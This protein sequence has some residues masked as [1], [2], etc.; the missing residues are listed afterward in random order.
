MHKLS[1]NSK[2]FIPRGFSETEKYEKM[3]LQRILSQEII[4]GD[5]DLKNNQFITGLGNIKEVR[6]SLDL[7]KSSIK[8]L[9]RLERVEGHLNLFNSKIEDLGNFKYVGGY[10]NLF[11]TP[12]KSLKNLEYVG[13]CLDLINSKIEDL[14]NLKYVGRDLYLDNTPLSKKFQSPEELE[15]YIRSKTEVK[16]GI[17][18]V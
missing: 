4:E 9:S 5:L 6:G 12:I 2:Y 14:G 17:Y 1:F 10:F 15:Q 13:G 16:G 8:S 11:E 3:R 18:V 7:P